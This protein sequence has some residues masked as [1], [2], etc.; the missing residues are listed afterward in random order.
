MTETKYSCYFRFDSVTAI[1]EFA[2]QRYQ[3][4][5]IRKESCGSNFWVRG[6]LPNGRNFR[7]MIVHF[8]GEMAYVVHLPPDP[9]E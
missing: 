2:R 4:I 3:A 5:D 1:L 8:E 6:T 9:D 7:R